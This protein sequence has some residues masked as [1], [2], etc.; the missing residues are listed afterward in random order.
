MNKSKTK[1]MVV[2]PLIESLQHAVKVLTTERDE[3]KE[4]IERLTKGYEEA[5]VQREK[6][7]NVA[8]AERDYCH[9]Q[10]LYAHRL[11][12]TGAKLDD[13]EKMRVV[14]GLIVGE[15]KPR[16]NPWWNMATLGLLGSIGAIAASIYT[17][18]KDGAK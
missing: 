16:D 8:T 18:K 6:Q 14:F 15:T 4:I 9:S 7:L 10:L 3:L 1:K 12:A 11:A 17:T 2:N 5:R 13:I